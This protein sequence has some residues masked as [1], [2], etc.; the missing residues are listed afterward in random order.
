MATNPRVE[1]VWCKLDE[2][3]QVRICGEVEVVTD[4]AT[5]KR[6]R[7]DNPIVDRLLPPQAQHLFHLYRLRPE[8]VYMAK[9]MV[10][11]NVVPW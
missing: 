9:G 2:Q 5:L 1:V 11:Y 10:P 3:S 7:A 4:D 6:F 8:K